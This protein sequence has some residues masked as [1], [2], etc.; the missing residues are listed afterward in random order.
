MASER[1]VTAPVIHSGPRHPAHRMT[2]TATDD[3]APDAAR[4]AAASGIRPPLHPVRTKT[5]GAPRE[6]ERN[7]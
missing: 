4:S 3:P 1:P 6:T 2:P 5:P 7:E